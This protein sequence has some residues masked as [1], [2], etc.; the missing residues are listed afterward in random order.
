MVTVT[1]GPATALVVRS[2]L[3]GGG[4]AAAATIAA[5]SLGVLCWGLLSVL[6]ISAL[7]AASEVGFAVLK[8]AGAVVLVVLGVQALRRAGRHEKVPA[9][10]DPLAG[11][12]AFRDALLTGITNPK[13]ALFFVALFPQFVPA[14]ASVLPATLLMATTIVVLDVLWYGTLA[15]LVVRARTSVLGSRVAAWLER[16][17]GALLI[18]LGG[19]VAL[20]AAR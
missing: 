12:A 5:N 4:R 9:G 8:A 11:R 14:G 15:A 16:V 6:G 19:R 18:A 1:P 20:D 10:R 17:T 13:L 7:V 3:R 2:A